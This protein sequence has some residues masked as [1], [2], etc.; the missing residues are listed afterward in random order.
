MGNSS[1]DETLGLYDALLELLW[2]LGPR[3]LVG[4]CCG[5]LSL[6]DLQALRTVDANAPHCPIQTVGRSLGIT[7]SGATRLVARHEER[8]WLK[9]CVSPRDGRICCL[10]LTAQGRRA[11][12]EAVGRCRQGL[13]RALSALDPEVRDQLG[14][15]LIDLA[16][17]LRKG[18]QS[19]EPSEREMNA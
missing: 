7:K 10:A 16:E 9:R 18:R 13:A 19:P 6:S 1:A 15:P 4:K 3:G 14:A 2:S 11:C 12:E 8:G 17:A 5:D